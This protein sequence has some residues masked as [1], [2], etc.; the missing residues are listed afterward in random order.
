[1]TFGDLIEWV[2]GGCLVASAYIGAGTAA[3]LA[4]AGVF[5][6]YQAQCLAGFEFSRAKKDT[7]E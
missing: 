4:V 6:V 5:L 7:D 3:A 2:A 1:M